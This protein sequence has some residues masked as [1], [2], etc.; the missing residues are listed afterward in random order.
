MIVCPIRATAISILRTT[1]ISFVSDAI[2]V[3]E[4]T[5]ACLT[6]WLYGLPPRWSAHKEGEGSWS[7]FDVLGHL[8]HGETSD[9]MPR[10]RVI[11]ETGEAV[12]FEPFDRFAQEAATNGRSM[13]SLLEEFALERAASIEGLLQASLTEVDLERRGTH[14]EFGPVTI[15]QLLS[16]WVA[17]DLGHLA[18][19]ARAMASRYREEVG[20]WKAYLPVLG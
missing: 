12:P 4:R 1:M 9:W 10:L 18:Q 14:P 5:P 6:A 11:L 8:I 16:T 17:H 19:I 20:P 2:E 13:D 15:R 7:P 3:L